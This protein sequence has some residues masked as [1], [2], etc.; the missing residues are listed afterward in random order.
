MVEMT[1]D[2]PVYTITDGTRVHNCHYILQ[3]RRQW[4]FLFVMI[5]ISFTARNRSKRAMSQNRSLAYFTAYEQGS[6]YNKGI[7]PNN[8]NATR[9]DSLHHNN[10]RCIHHDTASSPWHSIGHHPSCNAIHELDMTD[11]SLQLLSSG[12]YRHVWSSQEY[13]GTK[14]VLKTLHYKQTFDSQNVQ[15]HGMDAGALEHL[16]TSPYIVDIYGYCSNSA[17]VDYAHGGDLTSLHNR[18]D[19]T[20]HS[21]NEHELLQIA[22]DVAAAIADIHDAGIVHADMKPNQFLHMNNG[23]YMLNDFNRAH[24]YDSKTNQTCGFT[25]TKNLGAVRC[26][27]MTVQYTL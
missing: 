15:R 24:Y 7:L 12:T 2:R 9:A 4:R 5:V 16:S 25:E 18:G 23:R 8:N 19:N 10:T 21:N 26:V 27:L 20:L 14:R 11:S 1:F 13:N 3:M 22:H 6:D 17:L